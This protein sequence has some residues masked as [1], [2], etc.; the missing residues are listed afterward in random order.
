MSRK[1]RSRS[2]ASSDPALHVERA[3]TRQSIAVHGWRDERQV[4]RIDVAVQ[5]QRPA[6]L[7]AVEADEHCG[8]WR[9]TGHRPLDAEAV[10]AQDLGEP[11]GG[12]TCL[13][14]PTRDGDE[15]DGCVEKPVAP[16]GSPK[17]VGDWK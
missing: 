7:A 14:G 17:S 6:G 10:C 4:H 2:T 13:A 16:N 1:A 15:A 8:R 9:V 3:A 12:G 11:V 5:L